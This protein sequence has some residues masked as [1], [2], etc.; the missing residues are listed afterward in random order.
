MIVC[1]ITHN[2]HWHQLLRKRNLVVLYPKVVSDDCDVDLVVDS[3]VHVHNV[4]LHGL[5][6]FEPSDAC[7]TVTSDGVR[8]NSRSLSDKLSEGSY[9]FRSI[10]F[11]DLVFCNSDDRIVAMRS[12]S[13]VP[14]LLRL[15]F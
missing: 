3:G 9:I 7:A 15:V 12:V 2:L 4:L 14:S 10:L 11:L 8:V 13:E 6:Q 5:A 1:G